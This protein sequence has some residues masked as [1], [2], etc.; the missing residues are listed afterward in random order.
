MNHYKENVLEYVKSIRETIQSNL[1]NAEMNHV[2]HQGKP[3]KM[4]LKK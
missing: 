2:K 1:N 4:N 3:L